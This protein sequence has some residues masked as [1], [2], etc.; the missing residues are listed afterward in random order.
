MAQYR[1]HVYIHNLVPSFHI[2]LVFEI[3][4]RLS[5]IKVYAFYGSCLSVAPN[6][7]L[8]VLL[9]SDYLSPW[10]SWKNTCLKLLFLNPLC[11]AHLTFSGYWI[12]L[13]TIHFQ[14]Q[15]T[16]QHYNIKSQRAW[17]KITRLFRE[18]KQTKKDGSSW[19]FHIP[20]S[21][22]MFCDFPLAV[23]NF[24]LSLLTVSEGKQGEIS[25][26]GAGTSQG[27]PE[28]PMFELSLLQLTTL[29]NM[30]WNCY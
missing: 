5:A 8:W 1:K 14:A 11:R 15:E 30:L 4:G 23:W 10:L 29:R 20:S 28:I 17:K 6:L 18:G 16:G 13:I 19:V 22:L 24:S 12:C 9:I 7:G 3:G 25:P 2:C 26:P 21:H 27:Q